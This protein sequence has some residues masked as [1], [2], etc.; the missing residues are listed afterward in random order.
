METLKSRYRIQ[1]NQANKNTEDGVLIADTD[2]YAV[3]VLLKKGEI[4]SPG[5]PVVVSKSVEKVIQIGV[6]LDDYHQ[7]AKDTPLV[8]NGHIS[9]RVVQIG[10]YPDEYALRYPVEITFDNETLT[11]G[12]IVEVEMIIDHSKVISAPIQSIVNIDG[13][14]YVYTV[15]DGGL[16]SRQQVSLGMMKGRHVN[17]IGVQKGQR[18]VTEGVKYLNENDQILIWEEDAGVQK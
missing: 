4:V 5:A 8:I 17:V 14:D 12:E 18:I 6:K 15:D 7:I 3:E 11:M 9:G 10:A 1:K 2:G 16:V 13:I